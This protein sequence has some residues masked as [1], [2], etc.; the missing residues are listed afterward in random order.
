MYSN[1]LTLLAISCLW[2]IWG[3]QTTKKTTVEVDKT[4]STYYA[5]L[6]SNQERLVELLTGTFVQR[7][8]S[9]ETGEQETWL[10]NDNQDSIVLLSVAV[11]DPNKHGYWIYQY[12]YMTH[13]VDEPF[14]KSMVQ[15]KQINRDTFHITMHR[16]AKVYTLAEVMTNDFDED[17]EFEGLEQGK[18]RTYVQA[19]DSRLHFTGYSPI[20]LRKISSDKGVQEMY[21]KELFD[22]TPERLRM[23][24]IP[25][26]SADATEPTGS[27]SSFTFFSRLNTTPGWSPSK[28]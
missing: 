8:Q 23:D 14:Y 6:G 12:Q 15:I 3:C 21:L 4:N 2:L 10:V 25:Y 9:I 19:P 28:R 11:G 24:L 1:A 17:M 26:K 27:A 18:T 13:L 22:L 5:N 20:A 7:T 16:P